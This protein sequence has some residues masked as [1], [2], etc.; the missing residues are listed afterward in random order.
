MKINK[1]ADLEISTVQKLQKAIENKDFEEALVR[2]EEL[3]QGDRKLRNALVDWIDT[4]LMFISEKLGEEAVEEALRD[5]FNRT[6]RPFLGRELGEMDAEE[7]MK[8]RAYIWTGVHNVDISI[9]EDEEKFT[10]KWPCDTGGRVVTK[11][12]F[13]KTSRPYP[14]SNLRKGMSYYCTH[15][16]IAYE[17]MFTE[18]F[19]FPD[20]IVLPPDKPGDLCTQIIYKR[21]GDIP[22]EYFEMF[23][24]KENQAS[25]S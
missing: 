24:R 9:D 7:R 5:V 6:L 12:K 22:S 10:L 18:Q 2:L 23:A 15:C 19:G 11:E 8:K 3:R 14:W 25:I 16:T 13:G 17:I 1:W 4:H 20:F 21:T